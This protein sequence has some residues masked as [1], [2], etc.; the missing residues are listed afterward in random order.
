MKVCKVRANSK[1]RSSWTIAVFCKSLNVW[2]SSSRI[3]RHKRE[4]RTFK[5]RLTVLDKVFLLNWIVT[6]I[7][8]NNL[9]VCRKTTHNHKQKTSKGRIEGNLRLLFIVTPLHSTK[10]NS[11]TS[12]S[13]EQLTWTFYKLSEGKK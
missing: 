8:G 10:F 7:C 2:M 13:Y 4:L 3:Y 5:S 11:C 6:G 1:L 12:E 9:S